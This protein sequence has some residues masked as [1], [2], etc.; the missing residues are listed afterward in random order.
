MRATTHRILSPKTGFLLITQNNNVK[1]Y[2]NQWLGDIHMLERC[3]CVFACVWL[4]IAI[5]HSTRLSLLIRQCHRNTKTGTFIFDASEAL[6]H[7][8]WSYRIIQCKQ[9][10]N[11][12]KLNRSSS[13]SRFSPRHR[14]QS[15][16]R[17]VFLIIERNSI[18]TN[19]KNVR[20]HIATAANNLTPR[21]CLSLSGCVCVCVCEWEQQQLNYVQVVLYTYALISFSGRTR[22]DCLSNS[23][24]WCV[25]YT[26]TYP[27]TCTPHARLV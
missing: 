12:L 25:I 23:N 27:H 17:I 8:S 10:T 19:N 22:L 24:K 11:R 1:H 15:L 9:D 13:R 3:V 20:S 26:L 2:T 7:C 4:V 16:D 6:S 18:R 21:I 5:E 14:E